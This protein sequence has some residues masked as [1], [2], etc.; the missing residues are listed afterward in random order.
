MNIFGWLEGDKSTP[1]RK[2]FL[3]LI[4]GVVGLL[5]IAADQF[6]KWL[7]RGSFKLLETRAFIPGVLEFHY[8]T[9]EGASF[10]MMKNM[11]WLFIVVTAVV[12]LGGL[13]L[14]AARRIHSPILIW[15]A[16]L[17]ISGGIGNMIDRLFLGTV[18]DFL[19]ILFMPFPYIFNVADSAVVV[20]AALM[21]FY[22]IIDSVKSA[23]ERR[24]SKE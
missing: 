24:K 18:T 9:N 21:L 22:F 2:P 15:A 19:H 10:G 6:T 1:K 8:I 20:G 13:F 17:I 7:V 16:G 5:L 23:R 12:I 11:R 14:L 4:S 3:Y